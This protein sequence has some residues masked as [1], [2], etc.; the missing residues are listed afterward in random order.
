MSQLFTTHDIEKCENCGEI[1]D[2]VSVN[3]FLCRSCGSRED[4]F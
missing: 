4:N 2:E 1:K 3:I